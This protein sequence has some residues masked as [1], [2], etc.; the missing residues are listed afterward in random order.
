M[1]NKSKPTKQIGVILNTSK[2]KENIGQ[3]VSQV[4]LN[5]GMSISINACVPFADTAITEIIFNGLKFVPHDGELTDAGP[6]TPASR[7]TQSRHS[8]Q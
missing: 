7:E 8:V 3:E 5:Q 4:V 2:P 1:T 6:V